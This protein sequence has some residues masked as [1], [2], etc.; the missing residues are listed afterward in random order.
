MSR[1]S[2]F[3]PDTLPRPYDWKEDAACRSAEPALFFPKDHGRVAPLVEHEAKTYCARCPVVDACLSHALAWPERAGVWG[4]LSEDER[5]LLRRR[6]QRRARRAA[7]RAKRQKEN[8]GADGTNS[9]AP[10]S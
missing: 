6:I 3:A 1:P 10:A 2:R 5:R 7:A 8:H 4:G 9:P